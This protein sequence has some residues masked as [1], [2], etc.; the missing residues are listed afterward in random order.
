M[1]KELLAI[2]EELKA[3][4]ENGNKKIAE[5]QAEIDA[6][7]KTEEELNRAVIQAK[8]GDDPKAYAKALEEK[9]TAS[10]IVEYFEAKIDEIKNSPYI[11]KAEYE[12]YTKRIKKEMDAINSAGKA[13]ASKLFEELEAVKDEVVPAYE[14]ANDLLSILQNKIFKSTYEKQM[15]EARENHT[16]VSSDKLHNEYRDYSLIGGI[17]RILENQATIEIKE[18]GRN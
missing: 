11:T 2:E 17:N 3:I 1:M 12:A 13:K 5:Y 8:Q 6:A 9:R 18:G 14:K 4:Q 10:G 15:A 16:P 7:M